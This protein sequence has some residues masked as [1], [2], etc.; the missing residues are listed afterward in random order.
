MARAFDR[1]FRWLAAVVRA[2]VDGLGFALDYTR[3]L[4]ELGDR[5]ASHKVTLQARAGL[6]VG[7]VLTW[8]NSEAAVSRARNHSKWKASQSRSPRA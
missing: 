3:G 1:S 2:P 8:R 4:R 5:R 7:E 6:H